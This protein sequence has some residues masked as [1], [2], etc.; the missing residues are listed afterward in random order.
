MRRRLLL[1]TTVV[2]ILFLCSV[3]Y[4]RTWTDDTGKFSIEAEFVE[5]AGE[6][7]RLKKPD[8]MIIDV[9]L[10]K[11][12]LADRQF[13]ESQQDNKTVD[14]FA[15]ASQK[16]V[17]P[18]STSAD[19]AVLAEGSGTSPAE[20]LKD[21]FRNAVR[22]VVGA[23]VDAETLVK[24]DELIDDKI[25]T[26]SDGFIKTYEKVPGSEKEQDGIYV[27]E[28]K[29]NVERRSVVAK[30][31]AANVT[32]KEV[33][34]KGLF[35]EALSQLDAE[36]NLEAMLRK[37]FEDFPQSVLT[38]NLVGSPK[39]IDKSDEKANVLFTIRLEPDKDAYKAFIERLQ[40]KLDKLA[41]DKGDFSVVF[42]EVQ[43]DDREHP[44]FR[45]LKPK[46]TG[47]SD[48]LMAGWMPKCFKGDADTPELKT[49]RITLVVASSR[50]QTGERLECKYYLLDK[51]VKRLFTDLAFQEG[52]GKLSLIDDAGSTIITERF[53]LFER[54]PRSSEGFYGTLITAAGHHY[55]DRDAFG[56]FE[57]NTDD[58]NEQKPHAFLFLVGPAFFCGFDG[59]TQKPSL[60]IQ[61]RLEMSLDELKSVKDAKCEILFK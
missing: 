17:Q 12:C 1:E 25:L 54:F 26:Y 38:A 30:L 27:I 14:P 21:A 60:T 36:Q 44:D 56:F 35:A 8:G 47:G 10:A 11:L 48:E 59:L 4:G 7:V 19:Q 2:A 24:N 57:T 33:D 58:A 5:E 61:L 6:K 41:I 40:P 9:P 52:R 15:P 13:V 49:D 53:D 34:G 16:P 42:R 51:S 46:E 18:V 55:G 29:A 3:A 31:K 39:I 23:V 20:A 45:Y 28:I 43:N 32:V 22:Q 50:S 37:E